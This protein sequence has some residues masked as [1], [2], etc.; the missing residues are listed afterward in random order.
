MPAEAVWRRPEKENG[1]PGHKQND[2]VLIGRGGPAFYRSH[3]DNPLGGI[4][5]KENPPTTDPTAK[6]LLALEIFNVALEGIGLHLVDC[7]PYAGL[8][9]S[10]DAFKRLSRGPGEDDEP[11]LLLGGV[12]QA[13]YSPRA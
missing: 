11:L 7:G 6:R 3:I 8:V 9:V 12:H 5:P 2:P 13:L 1:D 10:G 4:R